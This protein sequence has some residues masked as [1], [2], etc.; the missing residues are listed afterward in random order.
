MDANDVFVLHGNSFCCTSDVFA[1]VLMAK[2]FRL[3]SFGR[4]R[5]A[6]Y[7]RI[8]WF[9]IEEAMIPYIEKQVNKKVVWEKR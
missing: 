7:G 5:H 1:N 2:G 3:E 9:T 8:Y 4:N 6:P